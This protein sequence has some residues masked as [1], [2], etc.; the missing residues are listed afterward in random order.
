MRRYYITDRMSVGGIAALI[1]NIERV[2]RSGV[3][4][5]QIREKNLSA[6]ELV[7][8]LDQVLRLPNP[9]GARILIN[10]RVD[11]ALACGAHGVHLP[12][13]SMPP[14]RLR[15]IVPRGFL[16]GVSCHTVDEVRRAGIEGADFTV[17]GPVFD[18][19]LKGAAVGLAQLRA[20]AQAGGIP[21]Y[22][23][24]GVTIANASSCIEAGAHG[25]AGISLFQ[26]V[27]DRIPG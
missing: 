22:A 3:E 15:A 8:L 7:R 27:A 17:F 12:A 21:V 20:A 11:I 9:H 4:M 26:G 2:L 25:I 24:G 13:D 16:I 14:E 1:A 10:G 18:T 6:R 19:P 23:L 5:I